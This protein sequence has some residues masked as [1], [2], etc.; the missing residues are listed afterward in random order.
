LENQMNAAT[1][2]GP[3]AS[4]QVESGN[5]HTRVVQLEDAFAR[6]SLTEFQLRYYRGQRFEEAKRQGEGNGATPGQNVQLAPIHNEARSPQDVAR[7]TAA[8]FGV[9]EKTIQGDAAFARAIDTLAA[10]TGDRI[11][12]AILSGEVTLTAAAIKRLAKEH[13]SVQKQKVDQVLKTG[14]LPRAPRRKAPDEESLEKAWRPASSEGRRRFLAKIW[15]EKDVVDFREEAAVRTAPLP[16]NEEP[17]GSVDRQGAD[18]Q[19]TH[20]Q[21]PVG[22]QTQGGPSDP[23]AG[24]RADT[25]AEEPGQQAHQHEGGRGQGP[26]SNESGDGQGPQTPGVVASPGGDNSQRRPPPTVGRSASGKQRR[27]IQID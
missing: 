18:A 21:P 15:S 12:H 1:A 9:D 16:G 26:R 11:R 22:Q 19:G 25:P 17:A 13:P 10:I 27:S 5:S 23:A 7:I 8:E 4:S 24:N 6:G 3:E 2:Q 20:P 14:K